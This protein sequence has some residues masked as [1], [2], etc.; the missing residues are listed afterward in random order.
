M[1]RSFVVLAMTIATLTA[2]GCGTEVEES[3]APVPVAL[4]SEGDSVSAKW[5]SCGLATAGMTLTTR[6]C[7]GYRSGSLCT[8]VQATCSA[9]WV[10]LEDGFF[11]FYWTYK[12]LSTE[13]IPANNAL[14]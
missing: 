8:T 6:S 7:S 1:K 11:E 12:T 10:G 5:N 2:A 3:E 4:E 14:Q 9:H 13:W